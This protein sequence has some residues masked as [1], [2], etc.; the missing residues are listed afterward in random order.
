MN[1]KDLKQAIEHLP[2]DM[3]VCIYSAG[4]NEEPNHYNVNEFIDKYELYEIEFVRDPQEVLKY[5]DEAG[6]HKSGKVFWVG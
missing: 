4:T 3:P 2:D 1:I 5:I 6:G